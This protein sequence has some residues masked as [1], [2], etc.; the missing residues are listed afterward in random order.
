MNILR[1]TFLYLS[2]IGVTAMDDNNTYHEIRGII[3][4]CMVRKSDDIQLKSKLIAE[5]GMDSLDF[6]DVIFAIEKKFG[7]KFRNGEF[8]KLLRLDILLE[9]NDPNGFI[10]LS[11][12]QNL[13]AY[14]PELSAS[15]EERLTPMQL[16]D[17]ISVESLVIAA[18][19]LMVETA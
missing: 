4:D 10:K 13:Q 17:M 14:L 8:E 7:I 11:E 15:A 12:L 2:L 5:L 3:A 16:F 18:N 9:N 1:F 6:L 19:E